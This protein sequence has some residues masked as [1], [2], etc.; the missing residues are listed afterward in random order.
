[1]IFVLR[2]RLRSFEAD[3]AES[4]FAYVVLEKKC[5]E[6]RHDLMGNSVGRE[7]VT[8]SLVNSNKSA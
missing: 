1:M 7:I 4:W 2:S 3:R 6:G 8:S 5:F